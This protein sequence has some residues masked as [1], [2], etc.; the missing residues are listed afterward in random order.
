MERIEQEDPE[1]R[2]QII[3]VLEGGKSALK[4]RARKL[5]FKHEI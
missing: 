3:K 2:D 1:I 5:N 4:Q